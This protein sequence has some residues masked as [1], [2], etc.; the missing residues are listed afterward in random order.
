MVKWSPDALPDLRGQV[1]LVTGA[2]A[3]VGFETARHLAAHGARIL[4]ACRSLDRAQEA[5]RQICARHPDAGVDIVRLDL[6]DLAS[7]RACAEEVRGRWPRL[8][9]LVNNAGVMA[10][11]RAVTVDG[12]ESQLQIN[13]LGHFALTGRLLPSLVACETARVVTVTSFTHRVG[14]I[15]FENLQSERDYDRWVA[16]AQS[17]LA[18]LLFARELSRRLR[19]AHPHVISV[20]CHPGYADTKLQ[21]TGAAA[22]ASFLGR[23]ILSLGRALFTQSAERGSWPTLY[24]ATAPDV[25]GGELVGPGIA[26]VW[27]A[28]RIGTPGRRAR[29]DETARR[30]WEVSE[31]LTGVRGLSEV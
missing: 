1:V 13:H 12:F 18:N 29:D 15:D 20:A 24:A 14:R 28:P 23:G 17:K 3:G 9:V 27:G 5:S 11:P 6:A 16:Y 22:S 30:L 10:I 31:E 2:N 25:S 21:A 26:G 4:L 7:V 19:A 8:D